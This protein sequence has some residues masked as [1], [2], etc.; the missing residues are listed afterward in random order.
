[1]R[2]NSQAPCGELCRCFTIHGLF[3]HPIGAARLTAPRKTIIIIRRCWETDYGRRKPG[4]HTQHPLGWSSGWKSPQHWDFWLR[5]LSEHISLQQPSPSHSLASPGADKRRS[6]TCIL[7]THGCFYFTCVSRA[8][9]LFHGKA[10]NQGQEEHNHTCTQK[11][12]LATRSF[13]CFSPCS[14]SLAASA[15]PLTP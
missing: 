3:N 5:L 15:A 7:V 12:P 10:P 1:M 13:N 2:H 9:C 6:L 4:G 8:R 14:A 11:S